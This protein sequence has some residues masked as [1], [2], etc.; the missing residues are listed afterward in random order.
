MIL[1]GYWRSSAAYRV[2]I[3]LNL[4]QLPY[5]HESIHLV[6]DGGQQHQADFRARNPNGLV[7]VLVDG[8]VTL[9]QSMAILEYLEDRYPETQ[10]LPSDPVERAKV[11][12]VAMDIACDIHPLNNL[13]ILKYLKMPMAQSEEAV[14]T[15]YQHWIREGFHAL[16]S[17]LSLSAGKFCFGDE[18]T[19]ADLCLVPQVYNAKRFALEMEQFPVISRIT[20]HCN[21]IDAFIQALPENQADAG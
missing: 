7:P 21:T 3:A 9:N 13:R 19:L 15:W 8:D 2:R 17:R 4:K 18:I 10:L 11:R 1:Y 20:E 5:T 16:E 6:K 14:N 12:A